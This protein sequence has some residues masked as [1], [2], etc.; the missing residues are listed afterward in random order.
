MPVTDGCEP[1]CGC[2][3]L[4]LGPLEEQ[5]E[6][7]TAEASLQPSSTVLMLWTLLEMGVLG[8]EE[9]GLGCELSISLLG[10]GGGD[11]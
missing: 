6:L 5:S 8:G 7:S 2:W 3:E 1:P 9:M 4:N 11:S 10:G